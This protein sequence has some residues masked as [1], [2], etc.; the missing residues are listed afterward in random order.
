MA[1]EV[2]SD[3]DSKSIPISPICYSDEQDREFPLVR[4]ENWVGEEA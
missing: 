2:A 1:P 3:T 4:D